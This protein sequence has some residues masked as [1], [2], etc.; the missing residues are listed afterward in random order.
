MNERVWVVLK[1]DHGSTQLGGI[2]STKA[3]AERISADLHDEHAADLE[4]FEDG[5]ALCRAETCLVQINPAE[6]ED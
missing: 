3:A 5:S 6:V 2:G 4:W 1:T